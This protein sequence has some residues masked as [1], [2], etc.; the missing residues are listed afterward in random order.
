MQLV[1]AMYV[2]DFGSSEILTVWWMRVPILV[3]VLQWCG[4]HLLL[5]TNS[6]VTYSIYL[7]PMGLVE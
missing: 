4:P 1:L 7:V 5:G 2:F 6:K 3:L